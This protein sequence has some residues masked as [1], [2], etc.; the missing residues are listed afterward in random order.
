MALDATITTLAPWRERE[1]IEKFKGRQD[2]LD[3]AAAHNIQV[4]CSAVR[5]GAI[6]WLGG[7]T[8][9]GMR[10]G[11]LHIYSMYTY[12]HTPLHACRWRRRRRRRTRW[13]RTS[14]TPRTS[15][16]CWRT[17]WCRPSRRCSR[18]CVRV[19]PL[20]RPCV[21][22]ARPAT[23]TQPSRSGLLL[24]YALTHTL[25]LFSHSPPPRASENE[26]ENEQT[27]DPEDA[28]DKAEKIRIE[29]ENGAPVKVRTSLVAGGGWR[30]LHLL[31]G[32]SLPSFCW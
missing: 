18:W 20:V 30:L 1:F 31:G 15:R 22:C 32:P 12:I 3:Y 7:S 26:N 25:I 10:H 19:S 11:V 27:V 2:L 24:L 14:T 21:G 29:F 16:A 8:G 13:T 4:R 23:T 28:P 5:R 17:P 6:G 9:D